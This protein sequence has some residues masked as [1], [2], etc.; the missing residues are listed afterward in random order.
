MD[1]SAEI[2]SASSFCST[3]SYR[4]GSTADLGSTA[5]TVLQP[6]TGCIGLDCSCS[7]GFASPSSLYL[8]PQMEP[9]FP[10]KQRGS[11]SGLGTSAV[12]FLV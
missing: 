4:Q 7:V 5:Q 1:H 8:V 11:R 12:F 10:R 3:S 9:D 2:G 6:E